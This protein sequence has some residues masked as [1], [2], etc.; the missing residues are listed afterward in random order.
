MFLFNIDGVSLHMRM[1]WDDEKNNEPP[2]RKTSPPDKDL[3]E[4]SLHPDG[5]KNKRN[6]EATRKVALVVVFVAVFY[7]FI[8]LL[9]L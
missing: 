9:F 3:P 6:E 4:E 1:T 2:W 8:K 7:F 5:R